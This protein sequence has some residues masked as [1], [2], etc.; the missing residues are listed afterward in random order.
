LSRPSSLPPLP[1][2]WRR[3]HSPQIITTALIGRP[4]TP[5][6]LLDANRGPVFIRG[7]PTGSFRGQ[8]GSCRTRQIVRAKRSPRSLL[9]VEAPGMPRGFSLTKGRAIAPRLLDLRVG[10][11]RSRPGRC[12]K[13]HET[14]ERG[15]V[16]RGMRA[17]PTAMPELPGI[18][19]R[20]C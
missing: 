8:C 16:R 20:L 15:P 6:R 14:P 9:N 1:R 12:T 10:C 17:P 18:K 2:I 5:G 7:M 13:L 11:G 4:S 3:V 19:R